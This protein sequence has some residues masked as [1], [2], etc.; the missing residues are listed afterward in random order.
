MLIVKCISDGKCVGTVTD[1]MTAEQEIE[2]NVI[3]NFGGAV[4]DYE[5]VEYGLTEGTTIVSEP[6]DAE[7]VAMAEAIIDLETRLSALEAV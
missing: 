2:L 6:V 5:V 1:G 7:K 4:E 3:P